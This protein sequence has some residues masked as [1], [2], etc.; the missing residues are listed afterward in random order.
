MTIEQWLTKIE[1]A[2]IIFFIGFIIA[3][4]TSRILKKV[5]AEAEINRILETAGFKP[6]SNTIASLVKYI[7]YII[8]V[9]II[10][11]QF[12]L[13][14]LVLAIIVITSTIIL[15]ISILLAIRDFIPNFAAGIFLRK[16]A[17]K[18]IG[19]QVQ[20]GTV[21]GKL[22]NFGLMGSIIKNKEQYYIPHLYTSKQKITQSR[23]D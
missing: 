20:I 5:L 19:K 13:T 2:I 4:L 9:F 22:V 12:G 6:I 1:I 16:K 11:Q 7:I 8:T 10:L 3:K 18:F 14:K 15:T 17:K 21:K 23:A